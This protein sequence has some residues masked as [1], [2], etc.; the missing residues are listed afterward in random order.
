[1]NKNYEKRLLRTLNGQLADTQDFD[2]HFV[3]SQTPL[4]SVYIKLINY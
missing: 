1:M 3:D 4:S 2:H